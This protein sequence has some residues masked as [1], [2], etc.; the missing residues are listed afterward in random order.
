MGAALAVLLFVTLV[1]WIDGDGY[2]DG[3]GRGLGFIDA[4]YYATV[5]AS[6]TGYGD[7]TPVTESARIINVLLVTP[8]RILFLI[9]LVGTTVEVLAESSRARFRERAWRRKLSG[10]TIVCGYGTKGRAAIEVLRGHGRAKDTV[11]V[12]DDDPQ[13]VAEAQRDGYA[14]VQGDASRG[15][16]LDAAGLHEAATVVVAV[17]RDDTAV[18]VTLTAREHRPDI[19][20]HAAVREEF[21]KHLLH[22]SGATQVITSSAAAGRLLGFAAMSPRVVEVL[23]DLLSVGTGLD[24]V[25]RELEAEHVGRSLRDVPSDAPIMAVVREDTLLRFDDTAINP[26]RAGDR[27]VCLCSNR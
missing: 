2:R 25:E 12:V 10:H 14:V 19:P 11:V 1:A 20:I 9:I 6:T 13:H 23:E 5:S 22:Q 3:D 15:A 27:L 8:A 24:V 16:V 21:N 7:I 18:L 26:L 17:A 4:L